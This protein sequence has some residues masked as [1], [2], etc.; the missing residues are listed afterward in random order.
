MGQHSTTASTSC[1]PCRTN[2]T[3]D[4]DRRTISN[5]DLRAVFERYLAA[6]NAREFDRMNEFAHDP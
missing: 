6:I 3:A 1:S 4:F 2:P 5:L